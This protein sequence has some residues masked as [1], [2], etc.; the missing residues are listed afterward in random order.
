M[1]KNEDLSE[2]KKIME[3][4]HLKNQ[5]NPHFMYNTLESIR[6]EVMFDQITA[7]DML[8]SLGRLM[9]YSFETLDKLVKVKEDFKYLED[10]LKLQKNKH[11]N[12][13]LSLNTSLIFLLQRNSRLLV[14]E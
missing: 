8:L 6:Y 13:S 5:F 10:Y 14:D 11:S 7:S 9:Q 1:T 12:F 4:K 2:T 3:I